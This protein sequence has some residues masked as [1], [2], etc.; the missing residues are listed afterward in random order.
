MRKG[1]GEIW[2]GDLLMRGDRVEK[3]MAMSF[4]IYTLV[5]APRKKTRMGGKRKNLTKRE[6]DGMRPPSTCRGVGDEITK[7]AARWVS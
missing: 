6:K 3:G 4:Y 1:P 2:R 5:G 7:G